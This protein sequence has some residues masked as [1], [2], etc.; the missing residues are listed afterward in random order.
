MQRRWR[1]KL[2]KVKP[3]KKDSLHPFLDRPDLLIIAFFCLSLAWVLSHS[4]CPQPLSE[5]LSYKGPLYKSY[6][7][8][9]L[10]WV[11]Y[12]GILL[13][14]SHLRLWG[15]GGRLEPWILCVLFLRAFVGAFRIHHISTATPCPRFGAV[16]VLST[17]ICQFTSCGVGVWGSS[18]VG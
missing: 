9:R 8:Y 3:Q 14:S 16:F 10:Y 11:Q 2:H 13:P 7:F 1:D 6:K 4:L 12:K 15:T 5:D 17:Q 18:N